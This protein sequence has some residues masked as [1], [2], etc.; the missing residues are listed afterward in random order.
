VILAPGV[1]LG[2]FTNV[3][4]GANIGLGAAVHNRVVVGG[5]SMTG[6]N[7]AVT[8]HV[9]PGVKVAGAPATY[10]GINRVGLAR[11]NLDAQ[12][13]QQLERW[14][15]N[16]VEGCDGSLGQLI[17]AWKAAVAASRRDREPL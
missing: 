1:L 7:A 15:G 8:T 9:R 12:E 11:S 6:M 17:E 5:H 13:V 2:G 3:G 4:P 14:I 10:R 16:P